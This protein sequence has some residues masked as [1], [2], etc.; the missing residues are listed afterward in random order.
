MYDRSAENN[1]LNAMSF[2][3]RHILAVAP[4]LLE[5]WPF[6]IDGHAKTRDSQTPEM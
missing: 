2:V 1:S 5:T 4:E 6:V 3:A